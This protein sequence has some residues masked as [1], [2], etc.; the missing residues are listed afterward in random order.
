MTVSSSSSY[1]PIRWIW[2]SNRP[3][4][5]DFP[6]HSIASSPSSPVPTATIRPSS[7]TRSASESGAPL[8]S[9]TRPP[10]NSVLIARPPLVAD[11]NDSVRP[12]RS[13]HG[14]GRPDRSGPVETTGALGGQ[15]GDRQ[16]AA[17]AHEV[18]RDPRPGARQPPIR[19]RFRLFGVVLEPD[20]IGGDEPARVVGGHRGQAAAEPSLLDQEPPLERKVVL[21]IELDVPA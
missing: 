16:P 5:S 15:A 20:P 19:E 21:R 2:Q 3:G 18:V 11:R 14:R 12:P 10:L 4:S 7:I 9:K 1:R 13:R 8:P 6:S 17:A